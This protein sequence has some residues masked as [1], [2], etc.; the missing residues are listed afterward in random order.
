MRMSTSRVIVGG[1]LLLTAILAALIAWNSST[2]RTGQKSSEPL[3]LYCAAGLKPVLEPVVR[4][5]EASQGVRVQ[6][7][8]GGSGTLLSNLRVAG[9]GDLFL[10]ADEFYLDAARSNRLL[11]ETIPLARMRPVIAVARGNPKKLRNLE[12]LLRAD[13]N[14]VLPNPDAAAIGKVVRTA[15]QAGGFWD[16]LATQARAFKPTVN[17]LA[18]DLKLGSADATLLWDATV[19]QYPEIEALD[20]TFFGES[21]SDV[22]VGILS[23]SRQPQAALRFARY[24]GAV[25]RGAGHFTRHGFTTVE[26]DVWMETPEI[27]FY[28][29][30]VNRVAIEETLQR[31]EVREGVR[32]TRIYNGCGILT[33]Q[34]KSGQRPDGYFACDV[35][36]MRN[37]E[38]EFRPALELAATRMVIATA[39]GNPHGLRT[40]ADLGREGLKL[41]IGVANEQQSALGAL[42]ARLLRQHGLFDSVMAS[43]VVQTPTADLL[44]NQLRAG[45]LDAVVV[46]E[47]NTQAARSEMEVVPIMLEGS[48]AIQPVAVG[49]NTRHPR[50]MERLIKTLRSSQSRER[51]TT[52]GF[53]WRDP[54]SP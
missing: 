33:A 53:Q 35:S 10:A 26:G 7:Q 42:T 38:D 16:R 44:V 1:S 43:V 23:F 12:D 47:A 14:L 29:G 4:E 25:D 17:D 52:N 13:V 48:T 34:I 8:Y 36:F 49:R 5:Y 40:L 45:G 50:L 19:K 18:N 37:V 20:G 31:F 6:V 39:K 46:Y 54:S 32:I 11:A 2:P 3:L 9:V 15:L 22:S 51:F 30:G 28:S 41:K 24:L 27:V 21:K